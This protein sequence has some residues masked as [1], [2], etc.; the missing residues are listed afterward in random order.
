MATLT[1]DF[2]RDEMDAFLDEVTVPIRIACHTTDG[3]PWIVTLWYVRRDDDLYCATSAN[4]KVVEYLRSDSHVAFDVSTNDPPYRG[5][6]GHGNATL[7]ADPNKALLRELVER[8]LGDADSRLARRLLSPDRDEVRIRLLPERIYGWDY[9]E[10]MRGS[11]P[12]N[13]GEGEDESGDD[14]PVGDSDD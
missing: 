1:G 9:T 4:A 13:D 14:G 2:S 12:G 3:Y 11:F 8:Y 5:V 6:R 7:K 10:R